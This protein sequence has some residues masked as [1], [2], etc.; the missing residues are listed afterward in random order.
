MR[1]KAHSMLAHDLTSTSSSEDAWFV[2]SGASN[3]MTSHD[4]WFRELHK[5]DRLGYVETRDDTI[6]PIQHIENIPFR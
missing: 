2:D 4:N 5:L 1:H 3:H 6:H